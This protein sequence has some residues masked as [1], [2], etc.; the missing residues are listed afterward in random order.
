MRKVSLYLMPFIFSLSLTQAQDQPSLLK[1]R[2]DHKTELTEKR[3]EKEAMPV[4]PS[5]IFEVVK[6]PTKL[7]NM[8]AYLSKA[9]DKSKKSPAI[10]WLTGGFPPA[11]P[12]AY[13]WE[14]TDASNEQSARI[15]RLLGMVMMFPTVRGSEP[16]N[17][18][19]QELMYGEVDD[20]ISA[21]DYLS[22][23]KHID[24]K[25]IY[26]GGHSTGGTLALLSAAATDK[27][28]GVISLGP[29]DRD[30][31]KKYALHK[32]TKKER[33]LRHPIRY[34]GAIKI[35]TYIIE[36]EYGNSVS[37]GA[38]KAANKNKNVHCV[39]VEGGDHFQI[40]HPVNSL[41]AREIIK[42]ERGGL[43]L[44]VNK[45]R[46]AYTDYARK[47]REVSDIKTLAYYRNTG[48]EFDLPKKV[49]FY[50]YGRESNELD[51]AV[52]KANAAGFNLFES[53]KHKDS[54][55]DQYYSRLLT[56]R[57]DLM[58]LNHLFAA[59]KAIEALAEAHDLQY[60]GWTVK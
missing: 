27:F 46:S 35:P 58:K 51:A 5:D 4:P 45:I 6:Y 10:I 9:K 17:P 34:L 7:G 26:L 57:I 8:S 1:L 36:G 23:L 50:L 18:G 40:I 13:L 54:D 31:G 47:Q 30:Y 59:T 52:K 15:Y 56:K 14:E 39:F 42:S 32:W 37:L 24:P 48:V 20:V 25:R 19:F 3:R 22:K 53:K 28:A 41:I 38:L 29:T 21:H 2:A 11:S 12:G 16:G 44:D 49:T 55:G 43:R 60:D 33:E